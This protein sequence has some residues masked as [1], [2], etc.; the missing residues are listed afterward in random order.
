LLFLIRYPEFVACGLGF[1]TS[2]AWLAWRPACQKAALLVIASLFGMAGP[3]LSPL[4]PLKM[5]N[6]VFRIDGL[7]GFQ[8]SFWLGTLLHA[9]R[10]LY[11]SSAFAYDVLPA[12]YVGVFA[13]YLLRDSLRKAA[14]VAA[15]FALNL[16]AALPIY[17]LFPVCG[18]R[19]A[20]ANFPTI[21]PHVTL[22]GVALTAPPNGVPSVHLAS[23]LLIL[24][25]LRHWRVGKLFGGIFVIFT[26]LATLGGGEHYL[27][28]LIMA[29]PYTL[30]I[31]SIAG[32]LLQSVALGDRQ[33][34]VA[35]E[36][37]TVPRLAN[38]RTN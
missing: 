13:I 10:L 38:I 21:P 32:R 26:I 17:L 30:A 15:A 11:L 24:W 7:L 28:D 35:L 14:E 5:D 33:E 20:F 4:C 3:A 31:V 16:F 23:A 12:M 25:F 1:L 27:F 37:I 19:Y 29:I 2:A 6:Y 9:H 8:P 22:H 18:P 34:P 36:A